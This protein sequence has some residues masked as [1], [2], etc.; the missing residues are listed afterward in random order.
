MYQYFLNQ[1]VGVEGGIGDEGELAEGREGHAPVGERQ[2]G[3]AA[4]HSA[5]RIVL[6]F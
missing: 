4:G 3:H 2:S 1:L 6:A 5:G